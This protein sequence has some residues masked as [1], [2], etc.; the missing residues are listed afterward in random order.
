M[1]QRIILTAVLCFLASP[2]FGK[3][4]RVGPTRQYT[5]PSQVMSLVASGDT[6]EIDAGLYLKD[7]GAWNADSL[8]LRCSSGYAHLDA[9][10]T[11]AQRKGIWVI[12]G[13]HT[14]VEG[15]EFSGCAILAA[16][17]ENGAGIRLQGTSLECRRCYFH[18]N[19]EGILTGQ[20]PASDILLEACEFARNGVES[21]SNAGYEHHIYIGHDRTATVRFCYFHSSIQGH[22]IK[23]RASTNYI[24]YNHIVDG[25]TGDGSLSIDLPNG[26]LSY[27]IGNTIEKGPASV[28]ATILGYGE[29]GII[30]ADSEYYV[31]NN[32]V[33][34]DRSYARFDTIAPGAKA[35]LINNIIAGVIR[36]L[37]PTADTISNI[38]SSDPAF[39]HF[40][41]STAY[42]YR[43][44]VLFPGID[45]GSAH[46]FSLRP[47]SMYVD[48]LDSMVRD[49]S[50]FQ[51]GAFSQ[52]PYPE[53][54]HASSALPVSS[55]YPD[56]FDR[57]TR[58]ALPATFNRGSVTLEL[59]DASGS[60]V[61]SEER[62]AMSGFVQ[63]LRGTLP[64]G[65]YY[66][67]LVSPE[68]VGICSGSV[69]VVP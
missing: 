30:N 34:V 8:V 58:I 56:P 19:Q 26:G 23:S 54:V 32:T 39:F 52:L 4:W 27:V 31:V 40:L 68:G 25:T 63:L 28:N 9:Q 6:V 7:V 42:D 59:Y 43:A 21:G 37:N 64:A 44:M 49:T 24:L 55:A 3:T 11:A 67:Q 47:E 1:K 65:V 45:P 5:A 66:Y 38:I 51:I 14:Y 69:V 29:E 10:R 61:L 57:E 35:K 48:R 13:K 12:N 53:S 36:P 15:I 17:G 16:D 50:S 22:E 60:R 33:V 41:S 2:L 46:G 18:D 62:P 20:D